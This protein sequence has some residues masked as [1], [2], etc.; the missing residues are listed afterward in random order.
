MTLSQQGRQS[1]RLIGEVDDGALGK[2]GVLRSLGAG[3]PERTDG[4]YEGHPGTH[5]PVEG[6]DE[7]Q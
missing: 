6:H 7:G 3:G 1:V 4:E 2:A 5:D